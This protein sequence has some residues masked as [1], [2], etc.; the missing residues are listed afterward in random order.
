MAYSDYPPIVFLSPV[1]FFLGFFF[2]ASIST[3]LPFLYFG[4]LGYEDHNGFEYSKKGGNFIKA[5]YSGD[6]VELDRCRG[7]H[8]F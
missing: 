6:C 5:V 3:F 8:G 7:C 2:Y 1:F 4:A